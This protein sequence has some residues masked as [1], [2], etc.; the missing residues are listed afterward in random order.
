[1]VCLLVDVVVLFGVDIYESSTGEYIK[2]SASPNLRVW[3][4]GW[5][6]LS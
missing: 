4:S 1:V 3:W 5:W 6:R 2:Y